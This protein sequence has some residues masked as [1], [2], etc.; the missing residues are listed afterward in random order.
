MKIDPLK[1]PTDEPVKG[2]RRRD[3]DA[4]KAEDSKPNKWK[5]RDGFVNGARVRRK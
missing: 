1:V 4:P 5:E 3:E 2:K